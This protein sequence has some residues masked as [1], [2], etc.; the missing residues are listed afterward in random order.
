MATPSL[1]HHTLPGALGEIAVDVRSGGR[2][3]PRPAVVVVHGFKGFKDW[4]MFPPFAERL[5]RAGFTAVT[6]NMS[7]S[8]VDASGSPIHPDR[9]SRNTYSAELADLAT[10]LDALAQGRLGVAP[11]EG[12]GLVGHSRGGGVAVLHAARDHRIR[13]LVTWSAIATVVRWDEAERRAWRARGHLD[14]VNSRTRQV[15][16]LAT[17]L[18]DEIERAD[19]ALD[20]LAAASAVAV[21]WLLVHGTDDE[22]VSVTDAEQL[23][24]A[25]GRPT[26]QL[27]R[28]DGAGHTFGAAH[29]WTLA[30]ESGPI[31]RVFDATLSWLATAVV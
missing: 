8:G 16:P 25:S 30:A 14:V 17:A 23:L 29:P 22:S 2:T 4:G 19:P 24:G 21:P 27:L 15:I 28:I 20:I 9:F 12:I 26:T 5:A 11:P 18:L 31:D 3:T 13:G 1:S 10:V 6:F 7:G